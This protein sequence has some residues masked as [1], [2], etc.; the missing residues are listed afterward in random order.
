[1][2]KRYLEWEP[3]YLAHVKEQREQYARTRVITP[4]ARLAA[5]LI[6]EKR[7][8]EARIKETRR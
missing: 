2:P 7:A 1:M 4:A 3:E 8:K 6:A 5:R